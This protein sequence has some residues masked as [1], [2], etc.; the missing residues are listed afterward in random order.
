MKFIG[1][2]VIAIALFVGGF[3]SLRADA[4]HANTLASALVAQDGASTAA[5]GTTDR[6]AVMAKLHSLPISDAVIRD[7]TIRP[8]GRVQHDGYLWR[9]KTP[10]ESKFP[11]DYY[12]LV[13]TVPADQAFRPVAESPCP[14]T[15]K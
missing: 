1:L 10:A 6:A 3:V 13:Q 9:V 8:D 5:A 11:F 14:M 15:A 4:H 12:E 2:A 7:A